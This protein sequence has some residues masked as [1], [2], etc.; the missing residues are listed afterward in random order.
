MSEWRTVWEV[1]RRELV[2][3]LRSRPL[4][5]SMV[6]VLVLAVGGAIA[7][8]RV[9]Q[10]TPTDDVGLVGERAAATAS[11]LRL[12]ARAA[13]RRIRLERHGSVAA[14]SRAVDDGRL[15]VALVDGSRLIVKRSESGPAVRVVQAA[16]ADQRAVARLRALG[17]TPAQALTTLRPRPLPVVALE[18]ATGE[19]DAALLAAGIIVLFAALV[20]YGSTVAASVTEEK[21]SRVVELVLTTVS[22]RSLLTGKVLG[23]GLLGLAQL[24][25]TGVA[26][27]VAGRLAGGSGLPSGAAATVGLVLLWFL[28]GYAFFSVAFAAV[29]ALVSRQ[30]DLSSASAPITL[31]LVGCCWLALF[32]LDFG[33][34]PDAT[35][36]Q[37]AAFVPPAAP[38]IVPTRVVAGDM[39]PLGL[40]A[41]IALELLATVVLVVFAARVYER[42]LLRTGA[43]VRL[44]GVLGRR[45]RSTTVPVE[46]SVRLRSRLRPPR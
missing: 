14:A 19:A 35:A 11:T 20:G 3:G 33:R 28:L 15:D 30:E 40:S 29:G 42:A 46:G 4:R 1:A 34:A 37:I 41:A 12:E 9:G 36:A 16:V 45:V 38:M 43:P 17:L 6:V 26:A 24:T 39:G 32:A 7:A 8:A 22:P 5:I 13:G 18:P 23:I 27:L 10:G 21:S 25:V 2:E 31:L 44:R